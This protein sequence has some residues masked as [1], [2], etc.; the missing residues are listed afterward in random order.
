VDIDL[1]PFG[2][3]PTESLA[4]AALLGLGPSSGYGVAKRLS[5]ARANAYQA[6]DGLVAKH[7][8]SLTGTNPRRYRAVQPHALLTAI[9]E[10]QARKLDRLEEQVLAEPAQGAE[11]LIRLEGSRAIRDVATR[12]IVRA[13]HEVLC[14][15]PATELQALGPAFRARAAAGRPTSAWSLGPG[16]GAGLALT[17]ELT[18]AAAAG[19]FP[20]PVLLLI[21][22]GALVASVGEE[23]SGYWSADPLMRALVL[24]AIS[25]FT[26]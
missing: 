12:G 18:D 2:F 19:R 24:A 23:T 10:A 8:A 17:G 20:S 7:A 15:A 16:G 1:T 5:I 26:G 22:D 21:A 9:G 11:P 25:A 14:V 4:Y 3:T 6:L 13:E